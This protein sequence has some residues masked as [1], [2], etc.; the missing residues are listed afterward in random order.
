MSHRESRRETV[1]EL[2][3]SSGVDALKALYK[4]YY[5]R[6]PRVKAPTHIEMRE[7]AFQLFEREPYVRHLS[8]KSE[9]ELSEYLAEKAPRHA[10]YSVALYSFPDAKSM[11]EKGWRGS[12]LLFDVDSDMVPDCVAARV[13][14]DLLVDDS[15]LAKGF[16]IAY[17]ISVMLRRDLGMDSTIYFTGNRGFHVVAFCEYCLELSRE[18]REEIAS[19]IAGENISLSRVVLMA[20]R[21]RRS[22][23]ESIVLS[24]NDPGWRGWIGLE[25]RER[26]LPEE[27]RDP[28]LLESLIAE[29]KIPI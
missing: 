21:A 2:K 29:L 14:D 1:V 7:F 23:K 15:C 12:E 27:V 13:G 18:E 19:Y 17:R 4:A 10:Y 26:G 25:L 16:R 24:P 8:F 28:S 3:K 22:S 6:K 9:R 5:A 20:R 11:E